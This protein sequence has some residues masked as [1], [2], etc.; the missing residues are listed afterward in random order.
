MGDA[1]RRVTAKVM[2]DIKSSPELS[3]L[4]T[5]L[6]SDFVVGGE[7]HGEHP[8]DTVHNLTYNTFAG[9]PF[10]VFRHFLQL[11]RAQTF[12]AFDYGSAAA[13]L[14][15]YGQP[16]PTNFFALYHLFDVPVRFV[17]GLRD[18]LIEPENILKH[19][20]T[21]SA[22]RPELAFLKTF[23]CGHIDFTLG[24]NDDLISYILSVLPAPSG[25]AITRPAYVET[26]DYTLDRAPAATDD[27]AE[28]GVQV[29]D[30]S[31]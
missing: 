28:D 26:Y 17:M 19:F 21:L 6:V 1:I 25:E 2:Q 23:D 16:R 10:N 31:G 8:F 11:A 3:S 18:R 13:N 7:R 20:H 22:V 24:L 27:L 14:A 5:Y 30:V 15:A 4:I 29:T 12:Q 9:T